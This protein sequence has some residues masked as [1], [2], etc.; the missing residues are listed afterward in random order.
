MRNNVK[1]AVFHPTYEVMD[2]AFRRIQLQREIAYL[3]E[4][5]LS[6]TPWHCKKTMCKKHL[7]RQHQNTLYILERKLADKQAEFEI[8][9]YYRRHL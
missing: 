6:W 2:Q 1:S 3:E 4:D 7:C 5:I 9:M 8:L